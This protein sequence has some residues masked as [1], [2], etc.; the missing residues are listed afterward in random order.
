MICRA[1]IP[2]DM[3]AI[4]AL[5]REDSQHFD[6][7]DYAESVPWWVVAERDGIIVGCCH[8]AAAMPVS[9]A[10]FFVIAPEAR[11]G[12]VTWNFIAWIFEKVRAVGSNHL[13]GF[14]H[15]N[16]PEWRNAMLRHGADKASGKGWMYIQPTTTLVP[17]PRGVV[18]G[19][20]S[21]RNGHGQ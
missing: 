17:A 4:E 20:L 2:D 12:T 6:Y 1:A 8:L 9:H 3:P 19:T 21:E 7:L 11:K 15:K 13:M 10:A 16:Q 14:A 5:L 18:E